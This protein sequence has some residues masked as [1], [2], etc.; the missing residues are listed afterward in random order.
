[1]KTWRKTPVTPNKLLLSI[2]IKSPAL[3]GGAFFIG[4]SLGS[5]A[6]HRQAGR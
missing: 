3:P 4:F 2:P 1:M 5:Y 6:R